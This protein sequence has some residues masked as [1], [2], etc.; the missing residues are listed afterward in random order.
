MLRPRWSRLGIHEPRSQQ[1]RLG[2]VALADGALADGALADGAPA[3]GA[4]ADGALANGAP[5]VD[6]AAAA[7]IVQRGRRGRGKRIFQPKKQATPTPAKSG[8]GKSGAGAA[9]SAQQGDR[10]MSFRD[11]PPG[12]VSVYRMEVVDQSYDKDG[13][14]R[15]PHVHQ[16]PS[17]S[18]VKGA[19]NQHVYLPKPSENYSTSKNRYVPDAPTKKATQTRKGMSTDDPRFSAEFL[20]T[21]RDTGRNTVF[22]NFGDRRRAYEFYRQKVENEPKLN[23]NIKSAQVPHH[24]FDTLRQQAVHEDDARS[25]PT[26]PF[27]VDRKAP[28]QLGLRER[29]VDLLNRTAIPGS[30][31]VEDIAALQKEFANEGGVASGGGGVQANVRGRYGFKKP[32]SARKGK[33]TLARQ[34]QEDRAA[35]EQRDHPRRDEDA[36]L[37]ESDYDSDAESQGGH[38]AAPHQVSPQAHPP[39]DFTDETVWPKL[40]SHR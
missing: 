12:P 36:A 34:I 9:G 22:M 13:R 39:F 5:G 4:P 3:D 19:K 14:A 27:N 7:A 37:S 15:Y 26:R 24:V 40:S 2:D 38:E 28:N 16:G 32:P 11:L 30:A 10:T 20:K 18:R 35:L 23:F 25:Y 17:T 21:H 1:N 6:Q 8:G 33:H 29:H 31:K